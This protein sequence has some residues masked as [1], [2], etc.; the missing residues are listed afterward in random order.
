M[1]DRGARRGGAGHVPWASPACWRPLRSPYRWR[2]ARTAT[3][4][5]LRPARAWCA[6]PAG[7][8][9]EECSD[10]EASLPPSPADGPAAAVIRARGKLV[11]GV[12]QNG[13]RR[14]YRDPAT[15]TP[16]GFG[17]DLAR[18][19]AADVLGG[20]VAVR[21]RTV[22]TD[23]RIAAPDS[24]TV[25]PVV[26]TMTINCARVKQV[27]F[28]T[29]VFGTGQQVLA[30]EGS[31][32][33][34]YDASLSGEGSTACEARERRSYGAVHR[35]ERD[36]TAQDPD[37]CTGPSRLDRPVRL[38]AGGVDAAVTDGALAAGQ[39]AQDPAVEPKGAPL[40]IRHHGAAAGLGRDDLVGRVDHVLVAYRTGPW[41]RSYGERPEADPPGRV[42]ARVPD[43]NVLLRAR[44][45]RWASRVLPVR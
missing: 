36:G 38:R 8:A 28:S 23:Q 35:D 39:A 34:R 6:R 13:Y 4:R 2:T 26:R 24:G 20:P 30:R 16:E 37:R 42:R 9:G 31:A 10:P 25:G 5:A 11:V 21:S 1:D 15:G 33:T 14:G 18:T 17:I 22:S 44:G 45:D 41:T 32:A 43:G 3:R 27:A 7:D 19:T 40:T 12:D 29:A